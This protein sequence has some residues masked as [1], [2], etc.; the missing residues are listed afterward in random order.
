MVTLVLAA[1][2]VVVV[3]FPLPFP[4]FDRNASKR[5]PALVLSKAAFNQAAQH[6]VLAMITSADQSAW[7]GDRPIQNLAE[8]GEGWLDFGLRGAPQIVHTG[9]PADHPQSGQPGGGGPEK[10][11]QRLEWIAGNLRG[12]KAGSPLAI[13]IASY[14]IS[15]NCFFSC[16]HNHDAGCTPPARDSARPCWLRCFFDPDGA[17]DSSHALRS[18]G[19]FGAGRQRFGLYQRQGGRFFNN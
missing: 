4:F 5:R 9:P 10:D 7:L 16:Q 11:S 3:P 15:S 18:G 8:S 19:T 12:I 13:C 6:S 1:F 17:L 14:L 2:D